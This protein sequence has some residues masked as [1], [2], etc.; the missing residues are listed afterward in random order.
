[1]DKRKALGTC[2]Q[3]YQKSSRHT[4]Q[5]STL[6]HLLRNTQTET[7]SHLLRAS[8]NNICRRAILTPDDID[9]T[10]AE[11][12]KHVGRPRYTWLQESLKEAWEKLSHDPFDLEIALPTLKELALRR[13]ALFNV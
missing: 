7:V 13:T 9:L 2:K 5:T 6:Q 4:A 11:Q 8:A 12:E 10:K 1:M 3:H